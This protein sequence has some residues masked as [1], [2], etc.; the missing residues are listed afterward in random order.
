MNQA[1]NRGNDIWGL[2]VD[3]HLRRRAV[4]LVRATGG[5]ERRDAVVK[6]A[7]DLLNGE[8]TIVDGS[9]GAGEGGRL[10]FSRRRRPPR[11]GLLEDQ[12]NLLE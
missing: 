10:W 8:K 3:R 12:I 5:F 2:S 9:K 11:I 7:Q 4:V 1:T 6:I